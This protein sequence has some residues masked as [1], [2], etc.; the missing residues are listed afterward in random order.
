MQT[1]YDFMSPIARRAVRAL[2]PL[3]LATLVALGTA[4][5]VYATF[6]AS[7]QEHLNRAQASYQASRQAQARQEASR[8][9]Q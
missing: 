5:G 9:I 3:A 4:V 7:A 8:R 2:A 6:R 1:L